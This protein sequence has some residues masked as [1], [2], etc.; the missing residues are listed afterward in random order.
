MVIEKENPL[1]NTQITFKEKLTV[2]RIYWFKCF[3][4]FCYNFVLNFVQLTFLPYT[5]TNILNLLLFT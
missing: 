2:L 1:L 5:I 3:K 4:S